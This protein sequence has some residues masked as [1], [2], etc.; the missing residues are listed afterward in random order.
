M[1]QS[2]YET[3]NT[4]DAQWSS[5]SLIWS[6]TSVLTIIVAVW[7]ASWS[8]RRRQQTNVRAGYEWGVFALKVFVMIPLVLLAVYLSLGGC[9]T[10]CGDA[11]DIAGTPGLDMPMASPTGASP[12]G[13]SP[14]GAVGGGPGGMGAG[15]IAVPNVPNPKDAPPMAGQFGGNG[16]QCFPQQGAT[17]QDPPPPGQCCPPCNYIPPLEMPPP[18]IPPCCPNPCPPCQPNCRNLN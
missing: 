14:S 16:A 9:T 3:W 13:A 6:V 4:E 10:V 11:S 15:M 2:F 8:A 12:T 18:T 5:L 17:Q 7:V 1:D